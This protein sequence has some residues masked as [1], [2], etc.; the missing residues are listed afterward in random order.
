LNGANERDKILRM[1]LGKEIKKEEF[2]KD[3]FKARN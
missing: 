3:G 1:Q 2:K